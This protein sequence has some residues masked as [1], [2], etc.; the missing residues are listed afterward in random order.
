MR[1]PFTAGLL[2]FLIPGVGQLYNGRILAGILWLIITPGFWIGSGG[3][4]GLDLSRHRC[5]HRVFV[6][7]GSSCSR[8]TKMEGSDSSVGRSNTSHQLLPVTF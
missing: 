4:A 1:D 3:H 5:L 6:R 8:I 7:E 2:S